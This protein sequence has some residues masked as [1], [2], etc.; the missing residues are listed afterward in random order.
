MNPRLTSPL[1]SSLLPALLLAG[2]WTVFAV[3]HVLAFR[4]SGDPAYLLFCA[5][6]TLTAAL[7]LLRS[8]ARSVSTDTRDWVLAIAATLVPLLFS[9]A[10]QGVLPSASVLVLLGSALQLAGLLSLNRSFGLVPA[11]RTV[12]TGG[13]YRWVRHP[14]YASYVLSFTG[15]LLANSSAANLAVYAAALV[16]LGWRT[17]REERHLS[18]DAEYRAYMGRVKYRLLPFF[19]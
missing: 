16:L 6:E 5:A 7:F 15:Y 17:L 12:K 1:V 9:P 13:V 4:R 18:R 10:R 8:P 11:L 14:L 19:F 3:A 2:A